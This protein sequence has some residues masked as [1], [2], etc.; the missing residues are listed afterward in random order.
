MLPEGTRVVVTPWVIGR[1]GETF[2]RPAASDA[3]LLADMQ[4]LKEVAEQLGLVFSFDP[5][6][7][8]LDQGQA[9]TALEASFVPFKRFDIFRLDEQGR[10]FYNDDLLRTHDAHPGT[11]DDHSM[12]QNAKRRMSAYDFMAYHAGWDTV[13]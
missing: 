9:T 12:W 1:H 13:H 3:Q 6:M 11:L 4:E 10:L 7:R 5:A 8:V 2:I